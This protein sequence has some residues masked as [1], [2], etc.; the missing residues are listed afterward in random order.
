M[1]Y[2][3]ENATGSG[4]NLLEFIPETTYQSLLVL[5]PL[6]NFDIMLSCIL[7]NKQVQLFE[8]VGYFNG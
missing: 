6:H 1:V 3:Y 2:N 7:Y 5:P 4:P 8:E